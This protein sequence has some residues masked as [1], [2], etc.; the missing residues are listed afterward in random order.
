MLIPVV[1]TLMVLNISFVIST[2]ATDPATAYIGRAGEAVVLGAFSAALL[3]LL[4]ALFMPSWW[5]GTRPIRWILLP[6]LLCS[7]LI[8]IDVVGRFGVFANGIAQVGDSYRL[9]AASPAGA[10]MIWLSRLNWLVHLGLLVVAFVQ[11]RQS[12]PTIGM[13]ALAIGSGWIIVVLARRVE[14]VSNM[15]GV[16]ISLPLLI[17]LAYAILRTQLFMLTQTGLDLALQA[18]SEAV[19]ILDQAGII[20]YANPAMLLLGIQPGLL[21][22]PL[23]AAGADLSQSPNQYG[24]TPPCVQQLTIGERRI[25]L[26]QTAVTNARGQWVGTLLLGRDITEVV[27]RNELLE[28]E[29]MQLAETVRQLEAEQRERVQLADTVRALSL[30]LIPIAAGVIVLPLIGEF[31]APR[32]Q[33][34]IETL[35]A[36]IE[37]ACAHLVLIDITGI[38]LLDT[39][40]A[41][42]ILSGIKAASLLGARCVLA[43]IRPEIAQTLVALGIPMDDISTTSTLQQAI[44]SRVTTWA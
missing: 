35:L 3:A 10:L 28:Q 7:A 37:E 18:M 41:N 26:T 39:A 19:A 40:G 4:S 13:L 12:R 2:L 6:Y 29:R 17:G 31:D 42:M 1:V 44:Q 8:L 33:Q 21:F 16:L 27:Q 15:F 32:A 20:A 5:E 34:F 9:T 11:Q 36:G 38:S 24:A 14:L 25:E 22:A 23:I 43:G 30:P